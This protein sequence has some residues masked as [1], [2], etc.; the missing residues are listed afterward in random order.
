[1][2][3]N[4][5]LKVGEWIEVR[6]KEEILRTLDKEGCLE[7]MPFMPEMFAY[8]GKPFQVY[9]RA[10]KGCDTI[11]PVRSRRF[12]RTIH[13]ETRCDGGGHGGCQ[14]GCLIYWKDAWVKRVDERQSEPSPAASGGCTEADV[15]RAARPGANDL[16]SNANY[17]CQVNRL[18]WASEDLSPWDI[19]QYIEDYTSGN[20]TFGQWLRGII[21]I[22]YQN[23]MCLGIGWGPLLRWLYE[24]FQKMRGGLPHP[25]RRGR[26]PL[27]AETPTAYLNLQEGEL[28][29]VKSYDVILATLNVANKNRGML[30]DGEM[31]PYCGGTYRV[32][33]RVT[34][35]IN[36]E[37][38]K[39]M[40]MKNPCIILENV[41]CQ[42]RYSSCRLF[43][44]RG[45]YPYWREIWLERVTAE[46]PQ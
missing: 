14:A 20:V 7:G 43:C 21:Y 26:I 13:L 41:V 19:R 30:F 15:L 11:F 4:K 5:P 28:V 38:G 31:M 29:R 17:M 45:I 23:L 9:K 25:N 40:E 12:K 16:N 10:H 34:R 33:K 8:C 3:S 37:T 22:T 44:P 2:T 36:E 32:K 42:A 1:V 24:K 27:G 6:S 46:Q 35:I 39:M 18:P